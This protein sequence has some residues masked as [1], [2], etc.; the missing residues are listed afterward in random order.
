[1]LT[2]RKSYWRNPYVALANGLVVSSTFALTESLALAQSHIVP[3]N[4]LG[5]SNSTVT[6]NVEIKGVPSEEIS[7][8]IVKGT[9]LLH[10]F[11][12]F[13]VDVG[14]GAYFILPSGVENILTRVTGVN[15]SQILGTLGVTG[16]NANL[17]FM[18]PNGIVFGST[19]RLD[20]MGSF[21]G[22]TAN[23]M[24]L[25]NGEI[26]S[27]KPTEPLPSQLL[28]VNP[29][30][31][32]FNQISNRAIPGIQVNG[33]SLSVGEGKSLVLL[34]GDI[35]LNAANIWVLD[36][37]IE[38]GGLADAGTV[39]L[40]GS[41]NNLNL[42]FSENIQKSDVSLV[43]RAKVEVTGKGQGGVTI[44]AEDIDIFGGSLIS[45]GI[46]SKLSATSL[47]SRDIKLNAGGSLTINQN[48]QIKN[49]V[50]PEAT[51]NAGNIKISARKVNVNGGQ[52]R[53][54]TLGQGNAG[55]I[56]VKAV[57]ISL[58]N[59]SYILQDKNGRYIS[60][61][62]A[63]I[64]TSNDGIFVSGRGHSGN[65][66]LEADGAIALIGR[67]DNPQNKII[68]TYTNGRGQGGSGSVFIKAG[69]ISLDNAFIVTSSFN[70]NAGEILLQGDRAISLRNN[71]SLVA[72]S[73]IRGDSGNITL[74]S[75]DFV[76]VENSL[77]SAN[78]GASHNFLTARGNAGKIYLSGKSI[79][80]TAG[81][82]VTTRNALGGN[83]G[84]IQVDATDLVEISGRVPK[85][86]SEN[87]RSG[88]A[89]YS[90]LLTS[91][92]R[93]ARGQAGNISIDV[94]NGT[95]R[96]V[97]G[98]SLRAESQG[99]F[100][101][102]TIAVNAKRIELTGGGKL[103][104]SASRSGNAGNITM[105]AS[106]RIDISGS[107]PN[108]DE[109]FNQTAIKY[110]SK[111]EA[112]IRLGT[113]GGA[114]GIY[115][116]TSETS[117]GKSG[118]INIRTG[119]LIVRDGA[120][121]SVSSGQKDAG[122][123]EIQSRSIFLDNGGKLRA[124]TA[125]GEGGNIKLQ[126][127]DSILMRRQ[128][129]ISADAGNNGNGGNITIDIPNGFIIGFLHEDSNIIANAQKGNGGRITIVSSGIYGFENRPLLT[130]LSDINASSDVGLD[131]TVQIDLLGIE[132][133][134]AR[135]NLPT[136]IVR[137]RLSQ[138][139]QD[140]TAQEES[141]FVMTG[142]GGVPSNPYELL[143][144]EA[145]IAH[146]IAL[147]PNTQVSSTPTT[148]SHQ[149]DVLSK[150]IVEATGWVINPQGEIVLTASTPTILPPISQPRSSS[151]KTSLLTKP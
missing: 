138:S 82:E 88:T 71:S 149:N 41:A 118:T 108:F 23:G 146:W 148:L 40:L 20:V 92:E 133:N 58:D 22:T 72:T 69:S 47:T 81:S 125:S 145:A 36:G 107:N 116:S 19:A 55:N 91:A 89:L 42:N 9:N 30:A 31:F 46:R 28:N 29:N 8:G 70:G 50:E 142:R 143:N 33:A 128:S 51:G 137:A 38:L 43:N 124:A 102:G 104:T 115:A 60:E 86:F 39:E 100:K 54:R 32:L 94:P 17:F 90:T 74:K 12:E 65:I 61:D 68:S 37:Q 96:V 73:F 10:S 21:V 48:S 123:L 139:C 63:A 45:T 34:G 83:A 15:P 141:R 18:N 113:V 135:I 119:Q 80:V 25:G 101:G 140:I 14:R 16:G 64:D 93:N 109:I 49:E 126:V 57:E 150:S 122:N 1:M 6:P 129:Q 66:Y 112:E 62:K 67:G 44:N 84:I 97:D 131:G 85:L 2:L 103:L 114:S 151:C 56:S 76:R 3:D 105:S 127:Q 78:I 95:L 132:P 59:P 130:S 117:T 111:T 27:T 136:E 147:V 24:R 98:A 144:D 26:F 121:L 35:S 110:K 75:S 77:I 87:N 7:G 4:S 13:N 79:F 52:I 11:Q 99:N 106:D 134:L 53:T 5:I 120:Q